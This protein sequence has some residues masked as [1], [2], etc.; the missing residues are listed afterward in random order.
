MLV[1]ADRSNMRFAGEIRKDVIC[2]LS[3]MDPFSVKLKIPFHIVNVKL[4]ASIRSIDIDTGSSWFSSGVKNQSVIK[5]LCH[6]SQSN[7]HA[8][9]S[10][11]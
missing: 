11:A 5:L 1:L 10:K 2:F 3:S 9:S 4:P 7:K 8:S 6:K